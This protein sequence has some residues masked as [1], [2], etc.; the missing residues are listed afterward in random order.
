MKRA[1]L[2]AFI[3]F[4][5]IST[6][7][8]ALDWAYAFVVWEGKVYEVKQEEWIADSEIGQV[9]GKVNTK[10]NDMTG[11]YYGNASNH[12]AKG[13]KYYE[14]K[15][16]STSTAIAV[17]EGNQWV[18]AAYVNEAPFHIMNIFTNIFFIFGLIVVA[19]I[20]GVAIRNKRRGMN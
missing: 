6:N 17:K 14:I 2:L 20:V 10:P 16:I 15:G 3:F 9:I 11:N 4:F 12:Y 7:V 1:T 19:L 5:I 13:T 18:K 8:R